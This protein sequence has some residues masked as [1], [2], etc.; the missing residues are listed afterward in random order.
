MVRMMP[1]IAP[2]GKGGSA[3]Y[4]S[5]WRL[6]FAKEVSS[7]YRSREGISFVV[8]GG[9]PSRNLS[10]EYSDLDLVVYWDEMPDWDWLESVP[11]GGMGGERVWLSQWKDEGYA[12]ES[13]RFGGLKVDFGHAAMPAW[14]KL[15]S[16]VLSGE[17]CSADSIGSIAGF[18]DSIPL[19]GL[20]AFETRRSGIPGYPDLLAR[21]V[22]EQNLRFFVEGYLMNQALGR[23]ELLATWDGVAS[24]LKKLLGILAALNRVWF[25]PEEPRWLGFWLDRMP[26]KPERFLERMN[27]LLAAPGEESLAVLEQLVQ[28]TLALVEEREPGIDVA[29]RRKRRKALGVQSCPAPPPLSAG[30]PPDS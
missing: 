5:R 11:L 16:E 26:A 22:I 23:G 9:S 2:S 6:G 3:G 28:E 21:K 1:A 20:A 30:T 19:S 18:L 29:S 10:D 25:S 17:D 15:V 12:L 24:T 7:A 27:G 13:Y 4:Q 14:E 8:L